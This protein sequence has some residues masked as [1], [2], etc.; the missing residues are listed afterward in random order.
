MSESLA[1]SQNCTHIVSLYVLSN[2]VKNI[3][4]GL[5]EMRG[6]RPC[7]GFHIVT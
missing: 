6:C 7:G 4:G 5:I 1:L 2:I 3:L